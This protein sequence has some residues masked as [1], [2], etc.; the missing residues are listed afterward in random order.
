MPSLPVAGRHTGLPLLLLPLLLLLLLNSCS[1]SLFNGYHHQ[2]NYT[3]K[4]PASWFLSDT[5]HFLFNTKIDLMKNHFSGLMIIKPVTGGSYRV[6]FITEVG[7]KIF[8]MEFLPDKQ[9]KV[10]YLMDAM[11]KKALIKTLTND[12]SLVLMNR[13]SD[14]QPDVLRHR[15]S[16]DIIYRYRDKS[17]K[18]FYHLNEV[19][20]RPYQ[21]KQTAGIINKVK[22]ELYGNP[23]SGIDS[24]KIT[25]YNLRLSINLYRII[26][27]TNDVAE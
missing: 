27:V 6:V 5:G 12:I 14:G 25:H 11:N 2:A 15:N 13:L 17:R 20:D 18:S 19:N 26:E 24:V 4:A 23:A 1:I 22:A 7:L 9:V 16:Q 10:H 21:V 3:G 8:D